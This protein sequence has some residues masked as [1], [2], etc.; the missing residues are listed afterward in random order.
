MLV[1]AAPIPH[2][3]RIKELSDAVIAANIRMAPPEVF[4]IANRAL[5]VRTTGSAALELCDVTRGRYDA[6]IDVRNKLQPCDIAAGVF[7]VK[8]AGGLIKTVQPNLSGKRP[9]DKVSVVAAFGKEFLYTILELLKPAL[10]T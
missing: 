9:N 8:E 4:E 6:F 10:L 5:S 7:I 1:N 3:Q 2:R